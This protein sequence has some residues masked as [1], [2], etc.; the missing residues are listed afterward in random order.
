MTYAKT[1][2]VSVERSQSE[3]KKVISNY[4]ASGF[5]F[6]QGN[7]SAMVLFE[8]N[9]KRVK[10]VLP[11]PKDLTSKQELQIERS[12]WRCLLLAIKA[13]L[14]CV[15]SGITTFEKEFLAH[16]VMPNGLTVGEQIMP[17][18]EESYKHNKNIPLLTGQSM[19]K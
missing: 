9:F 17:Q 19:K 15:E 11:L 3:I 1:T 18:I 6:G 10:F 8:I 12:R 5:V 7:G 2:S 4:G 16:I 14:E 13:K